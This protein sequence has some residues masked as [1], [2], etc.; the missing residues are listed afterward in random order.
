[1]KKIFV[2]FV[3]VLTTIG[4][5]AQENGHMYGIKSGYIAYELSGNTSGTKQIWWDDFGEKTRTETNTVTEI[6][7]FG[8][9]QTEKTHTIEVMDGDHFWTTNLI[10]NT[11]Q[12]GQDIH[13]EMGQ[14][15][16][17]GMTE[18]EQKQL[19]EDMLKAFNGEKL[20]T[21]EILGYTCEVVQAMGAKVWVYKGISFKTEAKI[22]GIEAHEMVTE[23]K[24]DIRISDDKFKPEPGIVY[25]DVSQYMD[26]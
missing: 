20:G 11:G 21:E 8:I 18:S 1:M 24:E 10:S 2:A 23:Y 15:I 19:G 22:M 3:F 4:L 5:S 13:N 14:E 9:K 26:Y 25:E 7:M 12:K 6:K 16:A 17:E